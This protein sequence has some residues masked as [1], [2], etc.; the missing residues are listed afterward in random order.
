MRAALESSPRSFDPLT[1]E[2]AIGRRAS[3]PSAIRDKIAMHT[4]ACLRRKLIALKP[5]CE[6]ESL[7]GLIVMA[8]SVFCRAKEACE[9]GLRPWTVHSGRM[10]ESA[11]HAKKR[12]RK[13]GWG[14]WVFEGGQ[15][16][17]DCRRPRQ[18]SPPDLLVDPL[19]GGYGVQSRVFL[20]GA[21]ERIQICVLSGID[22]EVQAACEGLQGDGIQT[23]AF[24]T[25]SPSQRFV[26]GLRNGAYRVL[27]A[28]GAGRVGLF[29]LPGKWQA[30][31]RHSFPAPAL[32]RTFPS[33]NTGVPPLSARNGGRK[34]ACQDRCLSPSLRVWVL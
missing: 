27:P 6:N 28:H 29:R 2:G 31:P 30:R 11:V 34:R 26:N 1:I 22:H 21:D 7:C 13:A 20:P 24:L 17:S 5:N 4:R 33:E 16:G 18:R 10:S 9:G 12:V 19:E 32:R 3:A 15:E 25:R 23:P 14:R 8:R